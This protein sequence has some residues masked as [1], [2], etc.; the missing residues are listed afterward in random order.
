MRKRATA[1]DVAE[2][3][4]VSRTTVSLVL[5]NVPGVRIREETRRRVLEAARRLDYHPDASARRLVRG[6]TQ[7]IAFVERHLPHRAFVDLFMAQVL[8]GAHAVARQEGFHI[9]IEPSFSA[10]D[11]DGRYL[12]L[13]RERHADGLL[14]SGPRFDD[15]A[16]L[17]L[18][19]EG[20]P[21]VLHGRPPEGDLPSVD[22]DNVGGAR[23]ATTHLLS[24]GHRRVA[25][26]GHA[27]PDYTAAHDRLEGYRQALAEAGVPFDESLVTFAAFTAESGHE[28]MLD[29]LK[30]EPPP[31]AVFVASDEV[32]LGALGA[33]REA[34][35]RVPEDLA[36]VGFDDVPLA[37]YTEPP[38]TTLRLPAYALGWVAAEMLIRR[39]QGEPVERARVRLETELVVRGSCG[40]RARKRQPGDQPARTA[41][42]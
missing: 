2:L 10:G 29:L 27:P 9:L 34:G 31:T 37:A 24:L 42:R 18:H 26:I 15:A 8:R 14:I 33:A 35:L 39:I 36:I 32:A 25:F 20:V 7:V 40:A 41:H 16:L 19:H 17:R 23:V 5:N 6:R 4:G 1:R 22:V 3:A 21:I 13:I 28:A 12:S 38:L 11:L 30:V